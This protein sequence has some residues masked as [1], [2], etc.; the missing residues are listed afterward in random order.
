MVVFM[1]NVVF[2]TIKTD[3]FAILTS[4]FPF[5]RAVLSFEFTLKLNTF[6]QA[7][8]NIIQSRR[9]GSQSLDIS[10][11]SQGIHFLFPVEGKE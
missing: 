7:N 11:N 2:E 10:G 9:D 3:D 1:A 4:Q 6:K 5:L 8:Q